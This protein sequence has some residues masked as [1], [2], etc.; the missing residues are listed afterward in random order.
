MRV[1]GGLLI[2][3]LEKQHTL[4]LY[5]LPA[6]VLRAM[7]MSGKNRVKPT[8]CPHPSLCI[9]SGQPNMPGLPAPGTHHWHVAMAPTLSTGP[10]PLFS[11][12]QSPSTPPS[13]SLQADDIHTPGC[14]LPVNVASP[15]PVLLKEGTL[16]LTPGPLY[17]HSPRVHTALSTRCLLFHCFLLSPIEHAIYNVC[18]VVHT[19]FLSHA[20][21][22]GLRLYLGS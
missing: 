12:P 8:L 15:A 2:I 21:E 20:F 6:V 10:S 22:K 1:K 9:C 7:N 16:S 5:Q 19:M 18:T 11:L 13:P 14:L 3:I 4:G 17:P